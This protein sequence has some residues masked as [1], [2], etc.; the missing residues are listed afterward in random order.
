MHTQK[1]LHKKPQ[2]IIFINFHKVSLYFFQMAEMADLWEAED[3][4]SAAWTD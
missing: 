4:I 3:T 1:Q 2:V